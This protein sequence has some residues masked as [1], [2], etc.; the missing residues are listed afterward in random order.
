[1]VEKEY[2]S[3]IGGEFMKNKI[4]EFVKKYEAQLVL[5]FVVITIGGSLVF[6]VVAENVKHRRALEKATAANAVT[7]SPAPEELS[8]NGFYPGRVYGDY[9][10][11]CFC[12][13]DYLNS[14]GADKIQRYMY[15]TGEGKVYE[16][17][18]SF[19]GFDWKIVTTEF[20][21]DLYTYGLYSR[22]EADNGKVTYAVPTENSGTY[23]C[24]ATSPFKCDWL[25]FDVFHAAT[26]PDAEYVRELRKGMDEDGCPFIGLG[27]AHYEHAKGETIWH[28]DLGDF[29]VADGLDLHY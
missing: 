16:L 27:M 4:K 5:S 20:K 25:I 24:D 10:D 2:A 29:T 12:F 1:M 3:S 6:S 15:S 7:Y 23:I 21:S 8:E 14:I 18:F 17:W 13:N 28:D 22:I 19:G 9:T 26:S 11:L